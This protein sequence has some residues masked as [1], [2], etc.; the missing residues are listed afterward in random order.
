M[1]VLK[2]FVVSLDCHLVIKYIR[3]V[4]YPHSWVRTGLVSYDF[5]YF[6]FASSQNRGT[7]ENLSIENWLHLGRNITSSLPDTVSIECLSGR[8]QLFFVK[9]IYIILPVYYTLTL[10]NSTSLLQFDLYYYIQ[11]VILWPI[12]FYPVLYYSQKSIYLPFL[13]SYSFLYDPFKSH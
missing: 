11:S 4:F 6:K 1:S 2:Q 13:L 8:F 3:Q 10:Y 9:W 7:Q 5:H 12:L